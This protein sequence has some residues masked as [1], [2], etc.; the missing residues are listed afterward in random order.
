MNNQN[1]NNYINPMNQFRSVSTNNQL[2]SQTGGGMNNFNNAY[3]KNPTLIEPI[4]YKNQGGMMHNN[5]GKEVLKEEVIEYAVHIDSLDR[6]T[7]IFKDPFSY[8][9][10][11][12]QP[13]KTIHK[14]RRKDGTIDTYEM[15]GAP[16]PH[17]NREFDNI[18]YIK[19]DKIML[20]K[21][22][23]I[24]ENVGVYDTF[25]TTDTTSIYHD[26]FVMLKIKE[27]DNDGIYATNGTLESS[28]GLIFPG[29][30]YGNNYFFG[31]PLHS[32]KEFK[33][34]ALGKITRLSIE[35]CDSEGNPLKIVGK[36]GGV[37]VSDPLDSA[38]TDLRNPKNKLIQNHIS[39]TIGV[40][41]AQ[42]NILPKYNN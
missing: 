27:I 20:P 34:S 15:T 19:L 38:E 6:D 22:N 8:I 26:R 7:T 13:N 21:Y 14:E 29:T 31:D 32:I 39:L 12:N 33:P 30:A 2:M 23:I 37:T 35:F 1:G 16:D 9:V 36:S 3:G 4:K 10:S 40:V 17:I 42:Q 18:K 25:D 5:M 11:F 28:F 24:Q 41:E